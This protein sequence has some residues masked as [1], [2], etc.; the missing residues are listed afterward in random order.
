MGDLVNFFRKQNL[1]TK[2][3]ELKIEEWPEVSPQ[4][5]FLAMQAH[6]DLSKTLQMFKLQSNFENPILNIFRY[7]TKS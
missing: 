2:E 7:W 3:N 6:S 4:G 1:Q 5:S